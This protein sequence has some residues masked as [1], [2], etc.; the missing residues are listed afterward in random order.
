MQASP[1]R[2]G[3]IASLTTLGIAALIGVVA[4]LDADHVAVGFGTGLGVALITFVAGATIACALSCL[5]RRR[6]EIVALVSIL[7]AGLALDLIVL[8]VWREINSEA[9]TKSAAVAFS[10]SFFAL[11]ILG[12]TLALG[13]PARLARWLYFA[14]V[15]A[16]TG[17]GLITTWLIATAGGASD[18][19]GVGGEVLGVP[20]TAVGNDELLRALGV[21][22]VLLAALWFAALAAHRLESDEA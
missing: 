20:V 17:A 3:A 22:F 13:V 9:Y 4:V 10:W 1:L 18:S 12:L 6:I 2:L 7:A 19:V 14:A 5:G 11:I 15:A 16:A 8:A 21:A